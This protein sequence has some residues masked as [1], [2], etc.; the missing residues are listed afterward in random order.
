MIKRII[1]R[2]RIERV[3]ASLQLNPAATFRTIVRGEWFAFWLRR[4]A[5]RYT[6]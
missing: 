2:I 4:R 3:I 6:V 1:K 5:T